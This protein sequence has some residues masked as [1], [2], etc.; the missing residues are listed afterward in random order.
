MKHHGVVNTEHAI[1]ECLA[2]GNTSQCVQISLQILRSAQTA[3]SQ[4]LQ[5]SYVLHSCKP[6][7]SLAVPKDPLKTLSQQFSG[8]QHSIFNQ[9]FALRLTKKTQSG[10]SQLSGG[11]RG[12][13]HCG[14]W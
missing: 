3:P 10:L 2:N 6:H 5:L 8:S 13:C 11:R 1:A 4:Y 7:W 9:V 14:Q 12:F